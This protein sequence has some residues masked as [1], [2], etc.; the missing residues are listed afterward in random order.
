MNMIKNKPHKFL[1]RISLFFGGI[2]L[3]IW[4]YDRIVGYSFADQGNA[5]Q[6]FRLIFGSMIVMIPI[7]LFYALIY[8]LMYRFKRPTRPHLNAWHIY[9]LIFSIILSLGFVS[10]RWFNNDYNIN[11]EKSITDYIMTAISLAVPAIFLYN[12]IFSLVKPEIIIER[13]IENLENLQN[14]EED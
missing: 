7:F 3:A 4:Q 12:I 13:D 5:E 11:L 9:T 1:F 6:F 8:W 14:E 10:Q 2:G